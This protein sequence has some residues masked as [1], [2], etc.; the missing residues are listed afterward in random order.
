MVNMLQRLISRQLSHLAIGS[1]LLAAAACTSAK[2]DGGEKSQPATASSSE[3]PSAREDSPRSEKAGLRTYE[4]SNAHFR[5]QYPADW[6]PQD[7]K[8]YVL[9]LY[10]PGAKPG[11]LTRRLTVD[12]PSLPP[13]LPG[14][15]TMGEVKNGYLKD[16]RKKLTG[17]NVSEDVEQQLPKS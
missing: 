7:D 13:H 9:A 17:M 10:P 8:D 11:D 15:I 16:L 1:L 14:M 2:S 5:L 3:K 12:V 6:T 4:N